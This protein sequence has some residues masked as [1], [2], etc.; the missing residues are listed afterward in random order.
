[1]KDHDIE[2]TVDRFAR[3]YAE[4]RFILGNP[5]EPDPVGMMRDLLRWDIVVRRVWHA[6]RMERPIRWLLR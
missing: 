3:R 5:I 2:A 6:L 4:R 1:M